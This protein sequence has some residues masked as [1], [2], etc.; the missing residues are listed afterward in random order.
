MAYL[1]NGFNDAT[2]A[3]QRILAQ[4]STLAVRNLAAEF[5]PQ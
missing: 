3:E 5:Q 2:H 1:P 4:F